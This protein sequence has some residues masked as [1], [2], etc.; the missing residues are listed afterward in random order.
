MT[1]CENS[2]LNSTS[3][4]INSAYAKMFKVV[5]VGQMCGTNSKIWTESEVDSFDYCTYFWR[6]IFT[7]IEIYIPVSAKAIPQKEKIE[8][9]LWD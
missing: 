9:I 6:Q 7:T 3:H 1:S 4:I 2:S 5:F 8:I